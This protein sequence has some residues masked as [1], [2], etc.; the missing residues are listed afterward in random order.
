MFRI[1]ISTYI[2][3]FYF[4]ALCVVRWKLTVSLSFSGGAATFKID[5]MLRDWQSGNELFFVGGY[6]PTYLRLINDNGV[7]RY[8][9][10]RNSQIVSNPIPNFKRRQWYTVM[11][12]VDASGRGTIYHYEPGTANYVTL[13]STVSVGAL[14][15]A[16]RAASICSTWNGLVD[17]FAMW[18]AAK[19][20][21]YIMTFPNTPTLTAEDQKDLLFNA[22]M[23]ECRDALTVPVTPDTR[24]QLLQ[25]TLQNSMFATKVNDMMRCHGSGDPHYYSWFWDSLSPALHGVEWAPFNYCS[26]SFFF[27]FLFCRSTR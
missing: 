13:S 20:P 8:Q 25:S 14:G 3:C 10:I 5:W 12:V 22:L 27:A 26:L 17:N 16:Y 24:T 15:C 4:S 11:I 23:D 7:A 18:N 1:S 9:F 2:F 19:P 21:S 6:D